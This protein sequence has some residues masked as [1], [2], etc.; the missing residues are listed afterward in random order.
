TTG[1][2]IRR[3]VV[4]MTCTSW[5]KRSN[6]RRMTCLSG[7]ASMRALNHL[8]SPPAKKCSPAP[9]MTTTRTASS[10]PARSTTCERASTMS[11]LRALSAFGRLS[12]MVQM[13]SWVSTSTVSLG[14]V[15]P[16]SG[17]ESLLFSWVERAHEGRHGAAD[18]VGAV[19]LDK[20]DAVDR[21]LVLVRPGAADLALA[22]D[23]DRAGLG[24]DEQLRH[25]AGGEPRAV[26]RDDLD[27]VRRLAGDRN[28]ARP[29]QGRP[30]RFA[31][32]GERPAIGV[33]LL[34]RQ[35]AQDRGGQDALDEDVLL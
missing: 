33:V 25:R 17:M 6:C 8:T 9:L 5:M 2:R 30:P 31:R 28:L 19:L 16:P 24:V 27:H 29:G 13:P 7:S 35:R 32:L 20:M 22:A 15:T 10:A 34:G 21:H 14:E 18:V 3:R 4:T 26:L 23:Q 12:V 1:F 11:R